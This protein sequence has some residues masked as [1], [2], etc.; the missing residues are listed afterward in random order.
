VSRGHPSGYP[1]A[2]GRE[3]ITDAVEHKLENGRSDRRRPA[4]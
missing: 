3:R 1:A 4:A 2:H